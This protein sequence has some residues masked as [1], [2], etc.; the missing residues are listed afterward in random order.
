ML[1]R[2]TYGTHTPPDELGV[3]GLRLGT[4]PPNEARVFL[5]KH[6]RACVY[7]CSAARTATTAAKTPDIG[8]TPLA[9]DSEPVALAVVA[10]T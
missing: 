8:A 10:R 7:I 5:S 3:F 9:E 2:C 4:T 6:N 1:A